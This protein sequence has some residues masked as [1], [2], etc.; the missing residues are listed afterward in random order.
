MNYPTATLVTIGDEILIG[1]VVDTNSAFIA[2]ELNSIGVS[3]YEIISVSD[4]KNHIHKALEKADK[5]SEI[6]ILTGGLGATK[7]DIT[8]NAFCD[9]FGDQLVFDKTVFHHIEGLFQRLKLKVN[10]LVKKQAEVPSKALILINDH[11]TA[12]GMVMQKNAR[13]FFS[14]PGVP[15]E[16]K[17]LMKNKVS[18]IVKEKFQLPVII[19][20][21]VLVTEIPE[22][23][24]AEQISEWESNLPSFIK[25]AYLPS[26]NRIRLR[27]TAKGNDKNYLQ[28]VIDEKIL[29]LKPI[30]KTHLKEYFETEP[31]ETIGILLKRQNQTLATAES[32]T[33]G[34]IAKKIT[35]ISGSSAYYKGSIIT[36]SAESK[37][38]ILKVSKNII[39]KHTVVS[40]EVAE[41]MALSIQKILQVDFSISTTGVA[42]PQKGEDG[43]EIGTVWIAVATPKREVFSK[44]FQ[45]G[46]LSRNDIIEKASSQAI[47]LLC[48]YLV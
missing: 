11:G 36:Y 35:S 1:Q 45:F 47:I 8:K 33:G 44:C 48:D 40:R 16:M 30:L 20:K 21:T 3:V 42:G 41:Q 43:K 12:S 32:C 10:S 18:P 5:Q 4:E 2:K 9:Y 19:H 24:L 13:L 34:S 17:N 23:I 37:V 31:E 38:N 14:L 6:I 7:D 22:S 39:K 28:R 29:G 27:L 26:L 46:K 25:L 15:L